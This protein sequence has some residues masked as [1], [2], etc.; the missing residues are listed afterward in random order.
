MIDK[1]NVLKDWIH[2]RDSS[3]RGRSNIEGREAD[4]ALYRPDKKLSESS[5]HKYIYNEIV[6]P[7]ERCSKDGSLLGRDWI[8][9]L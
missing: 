9:L 3:L 6:G 5:V 7:M 1:V 2:L 4:L 8:Y